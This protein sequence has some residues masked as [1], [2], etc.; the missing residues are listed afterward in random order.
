M[1]HIY[2]AASDITMATM[3]SYQ[4]YQHAL[5]HWKCVLCCHT[6]FPRFDLTDQESDR[7]HSN[8]PP[9]ISFHI[10]HL[11]SYFTVYGRHPLDEN[12]FFRLYLQKLYS[13][14]PENIYIRKD[15]VMIEEYIADFHTIFY[16]PA[17]KRYHLTLHI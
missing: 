11:I 1:R 16:T 2:A 14:P 15:L 10:Y 12:N 13:A 9:S 5:T 17:M 3:C 6:N 4:P 8:T 7:H